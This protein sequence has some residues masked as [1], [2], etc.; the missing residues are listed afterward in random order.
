MVFRCP[1]STCEFNG[2]L[3]VYVIDEDIY[4]KRP[5]MVIATVD[6]F[7]Q[8]AWR[9]ECRYLFGIGVDGERITSP[10]QTII[11]DELHL[12][13]GPLGSMVGLFEAIIENL[14]TDSRGE[15]DVKPKIISSTATIRRYEEQIKALYSR[16]R[17]SLFPPRGTNASDSFFGSYAKD[18]EG[19]LRPG[20]LY[21]GVHAP[22][23]GSL[24]TAQVRTFSALLQ[25]AQQFTGHARDPWWTLMVFFNSLRELGNS[26]SLLQSDIPDYLRT[27]RNRLGLDWSRIRRIRNPLEL[28]GRLR[29]NEVPE[30]IEK[31]SRDIGSDP[32]DV[33]LSSNIIEVG[34]DIDRLSH[35]VVVGQPKTTAQ[36]IQ[37]TGR[38]GRRWWER[39]A[40]VT[41]IYSP[42]K[43][44]DRSHFEQFRSYHQTLYAS[45]EPTSVTPFAPPVL[46]RAL[47]AV[48]CGYVRQNG[49]QD[50]TPR[51]FPTELVRE[52]YQLLAQRV[53]DVDDEELSTLDNVFQ[54][55]E[56]EWRAWERSRWS[57]YGPQEEP[58]LLRRA[59]EYASTSTAKVSW[60]TPV[61]LRDVD[62]ECR[63]EVS[64]KYVQDAAD[65]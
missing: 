42:T 48:L 33:C 2:G 8:L 28:T 64:L 23:L 17:V 15:I 11:Q 35:M 65:V 4:E 55:R 53:A 6:K 1:D 62:A 37:V 36:Y 49:Q 52:A 24:Q 57:S 45:V 9:P 22:G 63:A 40:I 13:S 61:S 7:A 29:S 44:R 19:N 26:L 30:A 46:D 14:C 21:V 58:S 25:S 47:H 41:T 12:I 60:A 34:I 32:V 20:R 38:V 50:L 3:P 43:P 27:I 18:S 10:P 39:P 51:P 56:R 16:N 5:P 59:G 54:R 31:L